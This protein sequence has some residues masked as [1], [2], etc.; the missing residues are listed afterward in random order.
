MLEAVAVIVLAA[1]L[2]AAVMRPRGLPEAVVAVPGVALL[3]LV[4]SVSGAKAWDEIARVGPVVGFL[5][6]VLALADACAGEGLF[7]AVGAVLARRAH[8][9]PRRLLVGTFVA[10]AVTTAVLSLDTTIVLLTPVVIATARRAHVSPRPHAYAVAHLA[11][12]AS[13]LLPVSNLTN[14]LAI[15]VVPVS[16]PRFAALMAL[17]WLA[18][19][20]VELAVSRWWFRADL[21]ESVAGGEVTDAPMPWFAV[22]VVAATLA[23]F[24]VSSYA[25]VAPV[26]AAAL[27]AAVLAGK[28]L[29]QR[30]IGIVHVV[31][32]VAPAFCVFVLALAVVVRAVG[33]HGLGSG[34]RHVL[35]HGASLASLIGIAAISAVAANVLN[36]LPA[37]LLLLPLVAPQGVGPVLAVLVGVDIGPNL[38][39]V[40]S[41][42]TL[43]WRRLLAHDV[44]N[45]PRLGEFSAL[46][47]VA[48][49]PTLLVA[50]V[51]L[52]VSI[53]Y[54][55][56]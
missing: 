30:R 49:A 55:G 14:L 31:H 6:A 52:W 23:G 11:N 10:A 56:A 18:S 26:W 9:R 25:G 54:V 19:V 12:T 13:S 16:F 36:N 34:L 44:D 48:V 46:A 8:A 43:L 3:L 41:L 33:D 20:V 4:G 47:A 40:G 42:A 1:V 21:R 29:A 38:T 53:R 7:D 5:A 27:G 37:T 24:L 15:A 39:Y 50:T 51:C 32:S 17:P 2:V 35:P 45:V 28:R 22:V